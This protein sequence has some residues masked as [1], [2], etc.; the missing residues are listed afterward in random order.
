[1]GINCVDTPTLIVCI[2]IGNNIGVY[3]NLSCHPDRA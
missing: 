3:L 2:N 1:M